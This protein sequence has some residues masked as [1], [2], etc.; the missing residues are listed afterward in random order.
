[1]PLFRNLAP[2]LFL[3]LA[4]CV[5]SPPPVASRGEPSTARALLVARAERGPVPMVL[6]GRPANL[7]AERLA[8]AAAK[9]VRA[10]D[11]VFVPQPAPPEKGA[12]L[13]L[14]LHGREGE[15]PAGLC[16]NP[17]ALATGFAERIAAAWCE[18]GRTVAAVDVPAEEPTAPAVERALWRAMAALFP[19][20]YADTYGLDL[21][22]LRVG[23][24]GT[25]GF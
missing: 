14:V 22:G 20:N 3:L 25:F 19:D 21:F 1:M 9:G 24:R 4:G 5:T 18:D 12:Y 7:S 15:L 16:R 2:L 6:E 13:L 11:V 10:V 23:I 17:R 8:E